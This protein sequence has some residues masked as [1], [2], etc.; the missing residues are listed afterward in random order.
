MVTVD[1]GESPRE[2][3]TTSTDRAEEIQQLIHGKHVA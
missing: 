3:L 1:R 2:S